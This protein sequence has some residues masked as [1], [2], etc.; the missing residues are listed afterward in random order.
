MPGFA[1]RHLAT[2]LSLSLGGNT[3]LPNQS[4]GPHPLPIF[5]KAHSLL[6]GSSR[7][8]HIGHLAIAPPRA[9]QALASDEIL[10]APVRPPAPPNTARGAPAPTFRRPPPPWSNLAITPKKPSFAYPSSRRP[11]ARP[12]AHP[13]LNLPKPPTTT[14]RSHPDASPPAIPPLGADSLRHPSTTGFAPPRKSPFLRPAHRRARQR[15]IAP[16]FHNTLMPHSHLHSSHHR[17][18]HPS[19]PH[20]HL[21]ALT[22]P[23]DAAHPKLTLPAPNYLRNQTRHNTPQ[24][25]QTQTPAPSK[26]PHLY[27]EYIRNNQSYIASNRKIS[28]LT[29]NDGNIVSLVHQ[30]GATRMSADNFHPHSR[31]LRSGHIE[32]LLL[33]TLA[34]RAQPRLGVAPC[35]SS[36]IS[37]GVFRSTPGSL[38][39]APQ[40]MEPSRPRPLR[41]ARHQENKPTAPQSLTN[42]TPSTAWQRPVNPLRRNA[43]GSASKPHRQTPRKLTEA[44]PTRSGASVGN[45]TN[46]RDTQDLEKPHGATITRSPTHNRP[47]ILVTKAPS[48]TLCVHA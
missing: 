1:P 47:K 6:G 16:R 33:K 2:P 25:M 37:S 5:P 11:K 7:P 19:T 29:I 9:G 10:F 40:P 30:R 14:T 26:S 13:Q 17:N 31:R 12:P 4:S 15:T 22:Q 39:P 21:P 24:T 41:V 20:H 44:T 42:H 28:L 35:A 32:M 3:T 48:R 34:T 8:P 46:T 38:L 18:R 27:S 23:T 43:H 45:E 36:K